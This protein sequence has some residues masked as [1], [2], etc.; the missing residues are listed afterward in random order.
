MRKNAMAIVANPALPGIIDQKLC[1][2]NRYFANVA[3]V[4][5]VAPLYPGEIVSALDTGQRYMGLDLVVGH[6]GQVHGSIPASH[7][8]GS[9]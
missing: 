9:A 2:P 4:V 1:S 3:G 6:W 7:A 8:G 5:A